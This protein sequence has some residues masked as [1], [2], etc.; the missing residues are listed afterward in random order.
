MGVYWSFPCYY[1]I[2]TV[3][4]AVQYDS[5]RPRTSYVPEAFQCCREGGTASMLQ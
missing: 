3:I 4:T 1:E 5:F 2:L